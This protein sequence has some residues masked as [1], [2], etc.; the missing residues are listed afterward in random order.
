[1]LAKVLRTLAGSWLGEKA[2]I[3]MQAKTKTVIYFA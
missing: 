1:M 2:T 3:S